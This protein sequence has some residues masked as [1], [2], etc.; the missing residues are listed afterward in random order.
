M[1]FEI[2]IRKNGKSQNVSGIFWIQ[3]DFCWG[4]VPNFLDHK[5]TLLIFTENAS[6]YHGKNMFS[7]NFMPNLNILSEIG[8]FEIVKFFDLVK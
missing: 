5:R 8:K 7:I 2:S 4:F 6:K 3:S 1:K